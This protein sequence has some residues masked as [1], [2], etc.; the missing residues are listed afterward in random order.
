MKRVLLVLFVLLM[1]ISTA[2]AKVITVVTLKDGRVFEGT[3]IEE[4]SQI[5][6]L[7]FANKD[8]RILYKSDIKSISTFERFTSKEQFLA[9]YNIT[10]EEKLIQKEK[11]REERLQARLKISE[12]WKGN[13]GY[14]QLVDLSYSYCGVTDFL[15]INYIGGYR[16]NPYIFLGV[17]TGLNFS[18]GT[19]DA[20][21]LNLSFCKP[22][23]VNVPIY[24]HFKANFTKSNWSPY[25]SVSAGGRIPSMVQRAAR[26]KYNQSGFLGD[27]TLGVD[28]K[29]TE[30]LSLYLG[31]G[32]KIESFLYIQKSATIVPGNK[33]LHGFNIHL[34]LSF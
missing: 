1:A 4:N 13:R 32:Y 14:R 17:G 18:L 30:K 10:K 12:K 8:I 33:F 6:R 34:G 21:K 15:G 7:E 25:V 3:K 29:I 31:I 2:S 27:I 22:T 23:I 5:I 20:S 26:Y 16:F 28:R 11:S 24:L 19:P 9:A